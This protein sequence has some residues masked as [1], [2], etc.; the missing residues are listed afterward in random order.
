[1]AIKPGS[2]RDWALKGSFEFAE[3]MVKEKIDAENKFIKDATYEFTGAQ[4]KEYLAYAW[5]EGRTSHNKR[6]SGVPKA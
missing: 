5:R 2:R 4:L 3:N 6:P 1:M